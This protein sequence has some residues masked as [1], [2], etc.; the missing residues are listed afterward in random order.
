MKKAIAI[1]LLVVFILVLSSIKTQR[2]VRSEFC[3]N[4]KIGYQID[5]PDEC[6]KK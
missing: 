1:L 5:I 4:V 6:L 2:L 3:D